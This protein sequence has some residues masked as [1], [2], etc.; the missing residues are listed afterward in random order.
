M[1]EVCT[2]TSSSRVHRV[3]PFRFVYRLANLDE[4]CD[5]GFLVAMGH[6][7]QAIG[8]GD[9]FHRF[10]HLKMRARRHDPVDKLLTFFISLV[11][12]CGYTS[13]IGDKLCPYPSVATAWGLVTG[14]ADQGLV[15]DTL[16]ALKPEH[17]RQ[18]EDL[19]QDLFQ[20]NSL[21]LRQPLA[22]PLVVDVDLMGIPLSRKSFFVE[23]AEAGYFPQGPGHEGLQ[24]AAAFIG[25]GFREVLGGHLAPG[26]AHILSQWPALLEIIQRRLGRPQPRREL[27]R[28][29][30][31]LLEAEANR[32]TTQ[33]ITAD[34]KVINLWEKVGA[35]LRKA[36][37]HQARI[38][39][40]EKRSRRL[41]QRASKYQE[42]ITEEQRLSAWYQKRMEQSRAEI[43]SRRDRAGAWQKRAQE[44]QQE[45]ARLRTLAQEPL[46]AFVPRFIILRG[47]S[48]TGT[49]EVVTTLCELGCFFVLK[50]YSPETAVMLAREITDAND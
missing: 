4:F 28:Q 20:H 43:L 23:G 50:G 37:K 48:H 35:Q 33:V 39:E 45:A 3:G 40:L 24:F 41:P 8:L 42:Q 49:A 44:L 38:A 15:N 30:A 16:H 26:S 1:P 13:D 6:F 21:A 32:L 2:F 10:I 11:D 34:R 14:F 47:D 5:H 17:L 19:F 27:L 29:H 7:S 46:E 25:E 22:A 31:D 18:I 36:E 12:G 9:A